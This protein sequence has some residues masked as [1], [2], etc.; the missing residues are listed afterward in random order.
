ML[1]SECP[2]QMAYKTN[3]S[4]PDIPS[5]ADD[6]ILFFKQFLTYLW[7]KC[8]FSYYNIIRYKDD[9]SEL[10]VLKVLGSVSIQIS[11]RCFFFTGNLLTDWI[12]FSSETSWVKEEVSFLSHVYVYWEV[13]RNYSWLTFTVETN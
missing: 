8:C 7:I 9:N 13:L 2:V 6:P 5:N 11:E 12:R 10:W 4:S 1:V 3:L